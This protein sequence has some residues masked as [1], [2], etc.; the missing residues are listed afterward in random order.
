MEGF[1]SGSLAWVYTGGSRL[2]LI[3][4]DHL[5][6]I[7]D[8]AG[9]SCPDIRYALKSWTEVGPV[10]SPELHDYISRSCLFQATFPR[11]KTQRVKF[12]RPIDN[13]LTRLT[14]PGWGGAPG[15]WRFRSIYH[16]SFFGEDFSGE[17]Q[18]KVTNPC[19]AE[20]FWVLKL[21]T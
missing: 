18:V 13:H 10:G 15:G 12:N 16:L 20:C 11:P 9:C 5:V 17:G 3:C 1:G 2:L 4:S 21:A 19:M 6:G 8:F 14:L 7:H